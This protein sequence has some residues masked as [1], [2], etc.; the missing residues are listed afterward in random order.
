MSDDIDDLFEDYIIVTG[1]NIDEAIEKAS[2][3]LNVEKVKVFHDGISISKKEVK[4]KA[5]ILTD[6]LIEKIHEKLRAEEEQNPRPRPKPIVITCPY[7]KST[8]TKKISGISKAGSIALWGV[9]AMGK[10][11]KQWHCN[12]CKSDF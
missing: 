6:E 8:N 10:A 5:C 9:F 3:I 7:C 11:G 4:L 12:N 2:E 1:K